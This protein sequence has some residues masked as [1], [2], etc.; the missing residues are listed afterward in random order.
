MDIPCAYR[1]FVL[2]VSNV[3]AF[4]A[5]IIDGCNLMPKLLPHF[6]KHVYLVNRDGGPGTIQRVIFKSGGEDL[7]RVDTFDP[8]NYAYKA[9]LSKGCMLHEK[10]DSVIYKLR[11]VASGGPDKC[12]V[13]MAIEY[14]MKEGRRLKEEDIERGQ[15]RVIG[16]YQTMAAYLIAN[17]DAYK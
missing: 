1:E 12:I 10:F 8:E 2:P 11:F 16:F 5:F 17:P 14:H 13:K 3:R 4:R 15:Q 7:Y 6:I 9:T